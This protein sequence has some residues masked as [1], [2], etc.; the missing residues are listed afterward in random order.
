MVKNIRL[1]FV[2]VVFIFLVVYYL[3]DELMGRLFINSYNDTS[4]NRRFDDWLYALKC[5]EQYPFFGSGFST[6]SSVIYKLFRV[7]ITAHN[8]FL[9]MMMNFGIIGS[10]PIL[11][12]IFKPLF[13]LYKKRDKFFFFFYIAFIFNVSIIEAITSFVF[14]V[15][16]IVFH[17]LISKN[18]VIKYT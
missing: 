5:I 13:I 3:P 8:S 2:V 10:L 18:N 4:Q 14:I 6:S 11:I 17:L 12:L 16:L 9:A 1:L 7:N 15:P